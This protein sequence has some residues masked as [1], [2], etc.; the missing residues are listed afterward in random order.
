M[1]PPASSS[2][3]RAPA[4]S[5]AANSLWRSARSR[6]ENCDQERG[7]KVGSAV[8]PVDTGR[9]CR[10]DAGLLRTGLGRQL[11][12]PESRAPPVRTTA[13][14]KSTRLNSS[15]LGISYAVFCLKK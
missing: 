1:G 5:P 14:R 11:A 6:N 8:G 2:C 3:A 9:R 4:I 13:D 12:F 10:L 7:A 15:H